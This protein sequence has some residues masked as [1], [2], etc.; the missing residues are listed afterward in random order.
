MN[1]HLQQAPQV[2]C[3]LYFDKLHPNLVGA[4]LRESYLSRMNKILDPSAP[5]RHEGCDRFS[6][7]IPHGAGEVAGA[8]ATCT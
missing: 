3:R 1:L 8:T 4:C 6:K 7:E 5:Q 2:F